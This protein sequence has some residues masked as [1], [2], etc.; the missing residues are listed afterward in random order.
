MVVFDP[1]TGEWSEEPDAPVL[2]T[3][4]WTLSRVVAGGRPGLELIGGAGGRS[5]LQFLP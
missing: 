5:N 4:N 1:A 2:E 3:E